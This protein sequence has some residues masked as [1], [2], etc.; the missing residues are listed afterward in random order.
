VEL[1]VI[2]SLAVLFVVLVVVPVLKPEVRDSR[3]VRIGAAVLFV[4]SGMISFLPGAVAN[5]GIRAGPALVALLRFESDEQLSEETWS[6][7]VE[8]Q[9]E[10]ALCRIYG[11]L[12]PP[13]LSA[14]AQRRVQ[15]RRRR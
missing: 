13:S 9:A 3:L 11:E 15:R 10:L 14:P 7:H 5:H 12:R 1:F 6:A 2:R 4:V 8:Q